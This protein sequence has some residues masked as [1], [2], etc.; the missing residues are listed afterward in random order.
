ML[1]LLKPKALN[2]MVDRVKEVSVQLK[3]IMIIKTVKMI[4]ENVVSV[5]HLFA[6]ILI[7]KELKHKMLC[8]IRISKRMNLL[9]S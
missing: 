6:L 8:L 9:N 2:I 7:I 4:M 3:L 1:H 5:A